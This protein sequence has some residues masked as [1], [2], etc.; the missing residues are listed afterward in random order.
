MAW[1]ASGS[2]IWSAP[3]RARCR[4][5][6]ARCSRCSSCRRIVA[7]RLHGRGRARARAGVRAPA[8][9][10]RGGRRRSRRA[11]LL[12]ALRAG[13]ASSRSAAS[14]SARSCCGS[15]RRGSSSA[16]STACSRSGPRAAAT[17]RAASARAARRP[18]SRTRGSR[19]ARCPA[20]CSCCSCSAPA[21]ALVAQPHRAR[22]HACRELLGPLVARGAARRWCCS[23]SCGRSPTT[24]ASS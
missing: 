20:G 3:G 12:R 4:A 24:R 5:T 6:P 21:R 14:C 17:P 16:A 10:R 18:T 11:D 19:C 23:T 22:A 1:R 2:A 7:A 8:D 9:V 15:S 13:R